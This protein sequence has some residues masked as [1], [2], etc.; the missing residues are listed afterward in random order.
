MFEENIETMQIRFEGSDEIDIETFSD[1]LKGIVSSLKLIADEVLDDSQFCKFKIKDVKKGSFI[2]DI[3]ALTEENLPFIIENLP[4]ILTI[5]KTILDIKKHLNGNPP[6]SIKDVDG[7]NVEVTNYDGDVTIVNKPI[8]N[9]YASNDKIEKSISSMFDSI[10]ND[11]DRTGVSFEVKNNSGKCLTHFDVAEV[12]KAKM[13]ID[14][15]KLIND[16][17]EYVVDTIVKVTKLDF[18]G[19][20]KWQV[21]L[22]AKKISVEIKDRDFMDKVRGDQIPF[23]AGTKLRVKMRNLY[24]TDSYGIPIEGS[25]S[26]YEVLEVHEVLESDYHERLKL[27][28]DEN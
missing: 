16:T 22:N 1:A 28:I 10:N 5:F 2:M 17:E 8:I 27:E 26:N 20:S 9:V 7:D 24:K 6:Y 13:Q 25:E 18:Y 12:K 3:I 19:S 4:T 23:Y 14:T 11:S 15:S 21:F